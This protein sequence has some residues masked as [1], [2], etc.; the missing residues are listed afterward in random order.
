[1]NIRVISVISLIFLFVIAS[2]ML[3]FTVSGGISLDKA[4]ADGSVLVVQKTSAGSIPHSVDITNNGNSTINVKQGNTLSSSTSQDLVIAENK[5][6]TKNSTEN[7]KAYCI[8]PSQRAVAGAKLIPI[9]NTTSSINKLLNSSNPNDAQ[10]A[11][12]TQLE[13]YVIV[14]GGNLNPY[15]GEP[16][17]IVETK[18]ITW[19]QFRQDLAVAKNNVMSTFNVTESGIPTLNQTSDNNSSNWINDTINWIKSILNIQ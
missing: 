9:N 17:A 1:M 12:N 4:Y 10:N 13:I 15:T 7:V 16:V 19:T 3:I 8:D 14:S 5:Q 6:I 11:Y 18:G 2:V